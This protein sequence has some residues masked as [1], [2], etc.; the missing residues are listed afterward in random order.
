MNCNLFFFKKS[1]FLLAG[2]FGAAKIFSTA[3]DTIKFL[4]ETNPIIGFSAFNGTGTFFGPSL[5][6][7]VAKI[8]EIEWLLITLFVFFKK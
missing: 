7:L 2:K 5:E 8:N 1:L 6:Y 4:S 3:L